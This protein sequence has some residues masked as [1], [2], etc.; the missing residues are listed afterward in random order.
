MASQSWTF[1][2]AENRD[3]VR[4]PWPGHRPNLSLHTDPTRDWRR[5]NNIVQARGLG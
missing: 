1:P 5:Q 2:L 3:A 4:H